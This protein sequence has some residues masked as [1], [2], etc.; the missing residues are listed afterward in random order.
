MKSSEE[1]FLSSSGGCGDMF[2]ISTINRKV[3]TT[4]H[5][6]YNTTKV[7]GQAATCKIF[8]LDFQLQIYHEMIIKL[9]DL[10]ALFALLT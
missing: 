3:F 10:K 2:T 6:V 1:R 9:I 5:T 8:L 7:K 4:V